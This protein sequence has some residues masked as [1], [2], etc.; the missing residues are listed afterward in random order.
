MPR[1]AAFLVFILAASRTMF[2]IEA[3]CGLTSMVETTPPVYLPLARAAHVQGVVILMAEIGT[4]GTIINRR[5]LSGPAMLQSGAVDFV[6]G[7]RANPYSGPRNCALVVSYVLGDGS[8]TKG[9]RSDPQHYLITG[10]D[11]PCL[12]DPPAE[13]G[14]KRK[15]FLFF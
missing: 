4:D 14:H 10:A 1:C 11:P 13:L 15:H 12:C 9:N 2:A 7:W 6:K 5:V 8:T 3:P